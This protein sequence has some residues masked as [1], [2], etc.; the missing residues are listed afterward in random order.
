MYT[1][2]GSW[3]SCV[4][5][6]QPH[7]NLYCQYHLNSKC[8]YTSAN[9]EPWGEL[10]CWEDPVIPCPVPWASRASVNA[11][12]ATNKLNFMN[13]DERVEARYR[14]YD[15]MEVACRLL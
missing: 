5:V 11:M 4:P 1:Q 12:T 14:T 7:S 2:D 13:S 3:P 9:E 8:L 6:L 10:L 15:D